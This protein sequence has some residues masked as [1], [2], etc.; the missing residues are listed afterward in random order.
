MGVEARSFHASAVD[1]DALLDALATAIV[2]LGPRADRAH[3]DHSHFDL[4][5]YGADGTATYCR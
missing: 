2:V 1:A 5:W 3:Q 4:A